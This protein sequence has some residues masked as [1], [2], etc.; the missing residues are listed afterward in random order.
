MTTKFKPKPQLAQS[1]WATFPGF[2]TAL[3]GFVAGVAALLTALKSVGLLGA[4]VVVPTASV[5]APRASGASVG[6]S[7][8]SNIDQRLDA[9]MLGKT[10][11]IYVG[12]RVGDQWRTTVAEG[13][14]PA[15]TLRL[16]GL[17]VRG[18]IYNLERGVNVRDALPTAAAGERPSMPNSLGALDIRYKVKV[19]DVREILLVNPTRV[20]VWAHITVAARE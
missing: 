17:P 8:A 4:P 3:G 2:I 9:A 6:V 13:M 1:W 5:P 7:D 18:M 19:D 20:W 14:E 10:G 16:D 15:K 11:W 12:T